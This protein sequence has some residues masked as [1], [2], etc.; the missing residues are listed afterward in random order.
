MFAKDELMALSAEKVH[1][2]F[3]MMLNGASDREIESVLFPDKI[4]ADTKSATNSQMKHQDIALGIARKMAENDA[5]ANAVRD[6][7]FRRR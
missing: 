3:T 1:E 2:G 5:K 6:Y 4:K 7:Y